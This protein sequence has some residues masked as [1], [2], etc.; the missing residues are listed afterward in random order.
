MQ[1]PAEWEF[2]ETNDRASQISSV[3][4]PPYLIGHNLKW[5]SIAATG[6]HTADEAAALPTKHPRRSQDDM[7]VRLFGDGPFTLPLRHAVHRNRMGS[8][9]FVVR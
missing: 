3:G 5:L 6:D 4:R 2:D 1:D 9:I 8:G 7:V